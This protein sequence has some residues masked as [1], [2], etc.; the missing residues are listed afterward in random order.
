MNTKI[1]LRIYLIN[2]IIIFL[3][4]ALNILIHSQNIV[5]IDVEDGEQVITAT[6][7][8]ADYFTTLSVISVGLLSF[9]LV[10]SL[11]FIINDHKRVSRR[12]ENLVKVFE[13]AGGD[14]IDSENYDFKSSELVII[15]KWNKN[16]KELMTLNDKRD[17]YFKR[18][19]HD[20]K[21]P[22]HIIKANIQLFNLGR[23]QADEYIKVVG[24]EVEVLESDIEKFLVLE[25][26]DYFEKKQKTVVRLDELLLPII[27][28]YEA[29]GMS[30]DIHILS[31]KAVYV[32]KLMLKK[33]V[34]NLIENAYKYSIGRS[35]K[36]IVTND[37]LLFENRIEKSIEIGDIFS[38]TKRNYSKSGNGLGV[39]IVN[40][41][42]QINE[43]KIKSEK[44]GDIFKVELALTKDNY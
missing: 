21:A 22:I 20:F 36:I 34:E 35:V 8:F 26:I 29:K 33:T 24:E 16:V 17:E 9:S 11:L 40:K 4:I 28:A 32:D 25:R 14:L 27:T 12:L 15:D 19:I 39:S 44:I 31:D 7:K 5:T 13:N 30:L 41:Y 37:K 38:D 43:W 6:K 23:E 3:I 18:M 2:G 1:Y 42:A 10:V